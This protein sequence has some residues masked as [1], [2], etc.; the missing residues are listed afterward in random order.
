[1][2]EALTYTNGGLAGTGSHPSRCLDETDGGA[3]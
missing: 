1:M 3:P 2:E